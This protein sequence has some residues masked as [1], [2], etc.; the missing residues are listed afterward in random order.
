FENDNAEPIEGKDYDLL[1]WNQNR[2]TDWQKELLGGTAIITDLNVS[3]T[4]GNATTSFRL[5]GSYHKEGTV[6]PGDF[7]YN[8]ITV[9]LN[10]NHVSENKK[11]E[12]NLSVN[13]GLDN[14]DLFN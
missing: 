8:K 6:F 11:F 7:D 4:G 1:L 12:V 9:G 2:Y 5:G 14:N 10:L 3:A 13:Y